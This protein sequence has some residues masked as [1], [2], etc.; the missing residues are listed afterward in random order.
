M[1]VVITCSR[2]IKYSTFLH[3]AV[4]RRS[5]RSKHTGASEF[6]GGK[7]PPCLRTDKSCRDRRN[8]AMAHMQSVPLYLHEGVH[9]SGVEAL[10]LTE[11]LR[12]ADRN[13]LGASADPHL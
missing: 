11:V 13:E 3:P 9:K 4:Y 10:Y 5:S 8:E 2:L 12:S 6:R 7:S 1:L